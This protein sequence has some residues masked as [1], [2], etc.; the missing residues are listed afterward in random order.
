MKHLEVVI[1]AAI[2]IASHLVVGRPAFA[3]EEGIQNY[4]LP[5]WKQEEYQN[6]YDEALANLADW[7]T[8]VELDR[9]LVS[10]VRYKVLL[11]NHEPLPDGFFCE[12]TLELI[13][14]N[15]SPRLTYYT[16]LV[17]T[18][19]QKLK[20][21]LMEELVVGKKFRLMS[22]TPI[23]YQFND[24]IGTSIYGGYDTLE[25]HLASQEYLRK[26]TRERHSP[27]AMEFPS[28]FKASDVPYL[29]GY[30]LMYFEN[31]NGEEQKYIEDFLAKLGEVIVINDL[32]LELRY[33]GMVD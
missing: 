5:T 18:Q 8:E 21:W 17:S 23:Y 12:K 7:C 27:D 30:L 20:H 11:Q 19:D 24:F 6:Y 29:G 3:N 15:W 9:A 33:L 13:R 26:I 22:T 16:T 14:D 25:E 31:P 10:I 28:W 32:I 4:Q 2:F 1:M